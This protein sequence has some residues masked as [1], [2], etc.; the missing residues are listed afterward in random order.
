MNFV[1]NKHSEYT[2]IAESKDNFRIEL[3]KKVGID[4]QNQL[5]NL[6]KELEEIFG[7]HSQLSE[8]KIDK[9]FT[10]NNVPFI[11]RNR[12]EILDTLLGCHLKIFPKNLGP[13]MI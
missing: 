6:S 3:M 1:R 9:Y 10:D 11:A 4:D 12:E 2:T 5:I 7:P 13:I 8:N